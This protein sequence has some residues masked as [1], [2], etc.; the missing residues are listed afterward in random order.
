MIVC[1]AWTGVELITAIIIYTQ[2]NFNSPGDLVVINQAACSTT[3]SCPTTKEQPTSTPTMTT[4]LSLAA[5][6]K[7]AHL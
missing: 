6:I 5:E 3:S 2:Y 7:E 1:F 4:T